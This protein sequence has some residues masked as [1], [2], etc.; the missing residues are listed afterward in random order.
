M[1]PALRAISSHGIS[2]LVKDVV[3]YLID[4][5]DPDDMIWF[6]VLRRMPLNRV[7]ELLYNTNLDLISRLERG[8]RNDIPIYS[9]IKSDK[10]QST[11]VLADDEKVVIT[12]NDRNGTD[13]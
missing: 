1:N 2:Y 11:E 3:D 4:T 5:Y 7:G 12:V 6:D 9:V 8:Y 10:V 13:S